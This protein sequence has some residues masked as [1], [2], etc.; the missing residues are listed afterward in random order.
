MKNYLLTAPV[1]KTSRHFEDLL[2][3]QQLEAACAPDGAVLVIAGAGSGKT[4]M[5][6]YR[7]AFLLQKNVFIR[8]G[9]H[10]PV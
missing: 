1:V 5:L 2:N 8:K 10:L 6:T 4:R 9:V 7:V 3:P